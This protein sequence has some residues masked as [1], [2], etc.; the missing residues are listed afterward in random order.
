MIKGIYTAASGMM[1]QMARQDVIAN[2]IANVNTA[3]FKK[4]NTVCRAFPEMLISRLGE[5]TNTGGSR[6]S[7]QPVV[8]GG[9]GTGAVVDQIITDYS[10]GNTKKT[11]NPLDLALNGEGYFVVQ[12]PQ[13]ERFTRDGC[14]KI[15]DQGLLT[16]NQGYAVMDQNN[17]PI[18]IDGEFS[19]D[20]NGNI[21]INDE[22]RATLKIVNFA[23]PQLLQKEGDNLRG[24]A[25]YT[26]AVNPQV[27]QG[28]IEESNVN[29][30]K[31]MVDLITVTRA[32]E[33]LQKLVQAED[34][35]LST[36]IDEVASVK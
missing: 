17:E 6:Q 18:T 15:N 3:G 26:P 11:D 22:N 32:Y 23:D 19:V 21:T 27:V 5:V 34:E 10:Q 16:T 4:D 25:A 24:Q 1:L 33:S 9:L 30:V 31:E 13:G 35:T 20:E 28:Y 29:A 14:F 8:I 12:T 2:N 7:I 36:A